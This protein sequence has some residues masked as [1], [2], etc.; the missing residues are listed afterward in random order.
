MK[1]NEKKNPCNDG[2]LWDV[3]GTCMFYTDIDTAFLQIPNGMNFNDIVLGLDTTL[4]IMQDSIDESDNQTLS[5]DLSTG[6]LDISGGNYV[7]IPLFTGINITD[8]N[9]VNLQGNG[10]GAPLTAEVKVSVIPGNTISIAADGLYANSPITLNN[11]ISYDVGATSGQ[12]GGALIKNTVINTTNNF[13]LTIGDTDSQTVF[14]HAL[15]KANVKGSISDINLSIVEGS[16]SVNNSTATNLFTVFTTGNLRASAYAAARTSQNLSVGRVFAPDALGNIE[17]VQTLNGVDFF[18][19]LSKFDDNTVIL[20]GPITQ[21]T[22][23]D[24]SATGSHRLSIN[25]ST[26][27]MLFQNGN[28]SIGNSDYGLPANYNAVD[29]LCKTMTTDS[30]DLLLSNGVVSVRTNTAAATGEYTG[31]A[32]GLNRNL[33]AGSYLKAGVVYQS[34]AGDLVNRYGDLLFVNRSFSGVGDSSPFQVSLDTKFAIRNA[35]RV[36]VTQDVF[37]LAAIATEPASG[38]LNGDIYYHSVNNKFRVYEQGFWKNAVQSPQVTL[39]SGTG[40]ATTF[41][42]PHG[43][44]YTPAGAIV[45]VGSA[46]AIAYDYVSIDATNVSVHYTTPPVLG[47]NNLTYFWITV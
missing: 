41:T 14:G 29:I 2:C 40:A 24:Y 7:V 43:L 11:G 8:T 23:L 26:R 22:N 45:T 19:G 12:L 5:F 27:Y 34:S 44:P 39:R 35:G 1:C 21:N 25:M 36:E 3:P 37:K 32:F 42:I 28:L 13:T 31:L 33:N 4:R 9:S 38:S 6:K 20:G 10:L 47:T 30:L 16:V 15:I 17:L 46:D 18:N